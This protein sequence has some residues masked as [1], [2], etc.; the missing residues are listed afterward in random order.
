MSSVEKGTFIVSKMFLKH[1][2][3]TMRVLNARVL[4][5]EVGYYPLPSTIVTILLIDVG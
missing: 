5:E 1:D 4:V 2:M 3:Q